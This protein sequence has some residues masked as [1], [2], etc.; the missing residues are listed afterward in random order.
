MVM[1]DDKL[2]RKPLDAVIEQLLMTYCPGSR[3]GDVRIAGWASQ[4]SIAKDSK[5]VGNGVT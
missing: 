1:V 2:L 3:Q 5:D 4:T